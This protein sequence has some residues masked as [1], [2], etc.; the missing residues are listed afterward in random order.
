MQR[1]EAHYCSKKKQRLSHF[2]AP[3][4]SDEWTSEWVSEWI[5]PLLRYTRVNLWKYQLH[6]CL[7]CVSVNS[8]REGTITEQ[9]HSFWL[10]NHFSQIHFWL[11]VISERFSLVFRLS[12]H[13]IPSFLFHFD[14]FHEH[15]GNHMKEHK[16]KIKLRKFMKNNVFNLNLG[17]FF[18]RKRKRTK[19]FKTN[20][21]RIYSRKGRKREKKHL[22]T[23]I[24]Y[25]LRHTQNVVYSFCDTST[26]L[27]SFCILTLSIVL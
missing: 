4:C 23:L 6:S 3:W 13:F 10:K 27:F 26:S 2:R 9:S 15:F 16:H 24:N 7:H 14:S 25:Y 11:F 1:I 5:S 20:R 22:T 8:T 17:Y 18:E 21:H 19:R 12:F